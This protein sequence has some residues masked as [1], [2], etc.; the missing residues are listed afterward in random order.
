MYVVT[1]LISLGTAAIL[2]CLALLVCEIMF[3]GYE[4][5]YQ[6]MYYGSP[7]ARP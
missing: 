6:A 2:K 1:L 7:E 3:L 4:Q 5:F